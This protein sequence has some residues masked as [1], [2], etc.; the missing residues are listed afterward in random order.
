MKARKLK[1]Y[2][3]FI[4]FSKAFD[5]IWRAGLWSKLVKYNIDGKIL[6]VVKSMYEHIKS[7]VSF[8]GENSTFFQCNNGLR[9]GENLSPILFS[10]F[11]NDM[12]H[13]LSNNSSVGLNFPNSD[14]Q[15]FLK[16]VVLLYAD[17]TVLFAESEDEMQLLLNDFSKY[18]KD[19][20]LNINV[21][22]TKFLIFGDRRRRRNENITL[23]GSKLEKVDAY[24]YLGI[25][26]SKSRSF[27]MT[28]KHVVEQARKAL[29][30]L[31]K[32]YVI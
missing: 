4:D 20:K 25:M 31:Y 26:F 32:K 3:T 6:T 17:D 15:S 30:S 9:Q 21:D 29:F 23:N 28:K 10:L 13:Y 1:L 7:C 5:T 27:N 24:K 2:C 22:K 12:E 8:N 19:W 16:I 11:V 14:L 18:C